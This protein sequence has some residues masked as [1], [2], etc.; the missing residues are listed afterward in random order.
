[1][2]RARD[3]LSL[4]DIPMSEVAR[5]AGLSDGKHLST[6]F[7]QETGLTPSTY[8]RQFHGSGRPRL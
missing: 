5:N 8:R 4:T 3:L 2:E 1:M 6:V 7:R